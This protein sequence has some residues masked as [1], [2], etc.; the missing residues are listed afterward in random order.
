MS[1]SWSWSLAAA[2]WVLANGAA[3]AQ[4]ADPQGLTVYH[5]VS[6][7]FSTTG[8]YPVRPVAQQELAPPPAPVEG[9]REIPAAGPYA[10]GPYSDGGCASGACGGGG[11]GMGARRPP[12]PNVCYVN[13]QYEP[14]W[15]VSVMG[16]FHQPRREELSEI[17]PSISAQADGGGQGGVA[18][19]WASG[20]T[21]LGRRRI[22]VELVGRHSDLDSWTVNN[23]HLAV[24]GDVQ[25]TSA[26]FNVLWDFKHPDRDWYPYLGGGLGAAHMS[27]D[28]STLPFN[29]DDLSANAFAYQFIGG[30]SWR[31]RSYLELF[32]EARYF[33]T[34]ATDMDVSNATPLV[35]PAGGVV[36]PGTR[37]MTAEYHAFNTMIG[38]RI[39]L[40]KRRC[41][42]RPMSFDGRPAVVGGGWRFTPNP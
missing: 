4:Y 9:P 28:D 13:E 2:G 36:A 15:Y 5:P 32:A 3:F 34:S 18:L 41:E 14:E 35:L 7:P 12:R 8:G 42:E 20:P 1:R 10:A 24:D 21:W 38:V 11:Y 40:G 17:N 29:D 26:M 23:A 31:L 33:G 37:T 30:V 16:G 19:G 6:S 22:E 25:V 27:I 39:I